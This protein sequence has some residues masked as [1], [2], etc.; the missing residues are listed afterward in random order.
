MGGI[1]KICWCG[2][3]HDCLKVNCE[4]H[5][6]AMGMGM[7]ETKCAHIWSC[8]FSPTSAVHDS[9]SPY[10]RHAFVAPAPRG[11]EKRLGEMKY[12][13]LAETI[14]TPPLYAVRGIPGSPAHMTASPWEATNFG[15]KRACEEFC[16]GKYAAMNLPPL[17]AVEHGFEQTPAPAPSAEEVVL[18]RMSFWR[19]ENWEAC[20]ITDCTFDEHATAT[21][22]RKG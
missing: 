13:W 16:L 3:S 1:A 6:E 2:H 8:D 19:P 11:E 20:W 4:G 7:D 10:F 22:R 15:T 9:A 14:S 18:H 12:D 17:H 21:I 5:K